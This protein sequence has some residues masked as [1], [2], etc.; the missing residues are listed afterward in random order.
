MGFRTITWEV[1]GGFDSNF[2]RK[3]ISAKLISSSMMGR[4]RS[5]V[6][7]RGNGGFT[8]TKSFPVA[9]LSSARVDFLSVL[10]I[11]RC[12][13]VI[14][15]HFNANCLNMLFRS[16]FNRFPILNYS[17]QDFQVTTFPV[18]QERHLDSF[19][20]FCLNLCKFEEHTL[21][22]KLT[23]RMVNGQIVSV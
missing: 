15:T 19:F 12:I 10:G 21:N 23:V 5:R 6:I 11:R 22:Y 9:T 18:S 8:V 13:C 3:C 1:I 7:P 17:I 16:K 14:K 20:E 4:V 2:V